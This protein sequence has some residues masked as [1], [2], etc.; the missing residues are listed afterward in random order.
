M[1]LGLF[2][3]LF[4]GK[5]QES[6]AQQPNADE[7]AAEQETADDAGDDLP[8]PSPPDDAAAE[9][10]QEACYDVTPAEA[11]GSG[12]SLHVGLPRSPSPYHTGGSTDVAADERRRSQTTRI[13]RPEATAP[14][15]PGSEDAPQQRDQAQAPPGRPATQLVKQMPDEAEDE[16]RR[17]QTFRVQDL[18][19]RP[20]TQLVKSVPDE[21]EDELRRSQTFRVQDL[22][23]RPP[24][25]LVKQ[26]PDEAEDEL[27]RSQTFRVQSP[28][29]ATPKPPPPLPPVA[30]PSV[31]EPA[32]DEDTLPVPFAALALNLPEALF[33]PEFDAEE[34]ANRVLLLPRSRLLAQL[35]EG[36]VAMSLAE[37]SQQ[38]P[39][40][41]LADTAGEVLLDLPS[42]VGSVPP[43][44]L[45]P[46][47]EMA[48]EARDAAE[49]APFFAP[50]DTAPPCPVG[51]PPAQPEP[52]AVPQ[53]SAEEA[54]A[55][56]VDSPPVVQHAPEGQV[57]LPAVAV[58]ATIP[59]ACRGASWADSPPIAQFVLPVAPVVAQLATGRVTVPVSVLGEQ[60]PDGWFTTADAAVELPL[61]LV[62]AHVP[63]AAL[64]VQGEE[65]AEVAAA[66]KLGS[67]F[68][69]HGTVPPC[70][71]P[72]PVPTEEPAEPAEEQ[73]PAQMVGPGE[74]ALPLAP[75]LDAVPT[76][77]R[78]PAWS[79]VSPQAVLPLPQQELVGQ[80]RTG[81]IVVS[82]DTLA[83][84]L[85]A[86]YLIAGGGDEVELPLGVVVAAVPPE[87]LAVTGEAMGGLDASADIPD[88]FSPGMAVPPMPAAPAAEPAPAPEEPVAEQPVAKEPV[89]RELVAKEPVAAPAP[90]DRA[91]NDSVPKT[92]RRTVPTRTWDGVELSLE[93]APRGVDVNS[94][95]AAELVAL[96]GVG[97]TRA[98]GIVRWR[99]ENGPFTSI[100]D[101]ASVPRIGPSLFRKMT[102]LSLTAGGCRHEKL[103]S[104]LAVGAEDGALLKRLA[105]A[106]VTQVG[107]V[108]C[109]LTDRQGL[110]LAKVGDM[111]ENG[112]RYAA[113]GSRYFLRTKRHLQQ[114]VAQD[115][116]CLIIPGCAPPL[117][118]LCAEDVVVVMALKTSHV[119]ARRLAQ[120]RKAMAEVAWLLGRRAVVLKY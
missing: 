81:R 67:F 28:D 87:A 76:A 30:Q 100:Y 47:A 38:V 11:V 44:L 5:P 64:G 78:G 103:D 86:G 33:G 66:A 9:E 84:V 99:E 91:T 4:R 41:W 35:A 73:T 37:L 12:E 27:R 88:I 69:P 52:A 13:Q 14:D 25:Q 96:P 115:A 24:S 54:V 94:A 49:M 109:V 113:L 17:S 39:A 83:Q 55:A 31:P 40:G 45:V 51:A 92:R 23:E 108:G 59:E 89:A 74:I 53:S 65:D 119:P 98:E 97:V 70:P 82:V 19:K 6:G 79:E 85:P 3:K 71:T 48:P 43:E 50:R 117:L 26:A 104:L 21:A 120:V 80:L 68:V 22:P 95:T 72:E 77:L 62:V 111:Q 105:V 63:V 56:E 8:A 1:A 101:L 10:P 58:L 61:G 112:D 18:G 57:C 20:P 46:T 29:G 42:V 34:A 32:S 106:L 75:L 36:R 114:F 2:K 60:L 7:L 15:L 90:A 116:D 110:S 107:A 118:L 16:L 102:G 93:R